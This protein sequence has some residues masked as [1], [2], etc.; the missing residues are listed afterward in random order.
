MQT[1]LLNPTFSTIEKGCKSMV[2]IS[3]MHRWMQCTRASFISH[4]RVRC[5]LH[6][7]I[8][9][10]ASLLLKSAS[11]FPVLLLLFAL[12]SQHVL[13]DAWSSQM[14]DQVCV[15]WNFLLLLFVVTALLQYWTWYQLEFTDNDTSNKY[16]LSSD[17]QQPIRLSVHHY[18]ND[19]YM[20]SMQK[21]FCYLKSRK[22]SWCNNGFKGWLGPL[23]LSQVTGFTKFDVFLNNTSRNKRIHRTHLQRKSVQTL[24]ILWI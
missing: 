20:H 24:L 7:H 1:R 16:L 15:C 4:M 3:P 5:D 19:N 14:S 11:G 22:E 8:A 12:Q 9:L 6:T 2:T 13:L 21:L 10:A 18:I 23:S 17:I